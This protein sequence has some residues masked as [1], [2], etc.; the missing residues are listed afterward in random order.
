MYHRVLPSD[1][2]AQ[3][4]SHPG[5]VVTTT[6]FARHLRFLTRH[7]KPL[8]LEEFE[9]CMT[10][11][12]PIP[13][14]ACLITFDDGWA[15]NNLHAAPL[16]S[17]YGVPAVVFTATDYIDSP[18]SFWQERLGYLIYLAAKNGHCATALEKIGLPINEDTSD[19]LLRAQVANI[20]NHY[21]SSLYSEIATLIKTLEQGMASAGEHCT[22]H[23][24]DQ[25]MSW[26][27]VES[28]ESNGITIGSHTCSHRILTRICDADVD[29]ELLESKKTL[30]ARISRNVVS[31]AYPNGNV[32]SIVRDRAEH[33]GY[34]LA[35]TTREDYV[36]DTTDPLLLPRINIHESASRTPALFLCRM[37]K[38]F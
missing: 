10:S 8:N 19:D 2:I 30:N 17:E 27:Q 21:R 29:K 11:G 3:T 38:I 5:I 22:N 7:F 6:T 24:L 36:S 15:D 1:E 25:F 37:L 33:L 18:N 28:L 35:F 13:K 9:H 34:R 32:N 12:D 26:K 31:L 16:L 20:V 14:G 23:P 4:F